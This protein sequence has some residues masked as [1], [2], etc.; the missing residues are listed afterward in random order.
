MIDTSRSLPS[1]LATNSSTRFRCFLLS[2]SGIIRDQNNGRSQPA[3]RS[4]CQVS[5]LHGMP[6][7]CATIEQGNPFIRSIHAFEAPCEDVLHDYRRLCSKGENV[8]VAALHIS[9]R[10]FQQRCRLN[11]L[12]L[13]LPLSL[14]SDSTVFLEPHLPCSVDAV[15]L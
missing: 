6:F 9:V 3:T 2:G 11:L 4:S 8:H 10:K 5:R 14:R 13:L 1:S 7:L 15:T 12:G